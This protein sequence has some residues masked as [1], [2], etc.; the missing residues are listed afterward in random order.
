MAKFT[1]VRCGKQK[2]TAQ[3]C[4]LYAVYQVDYVTAPSICKRCCPTCCRKLPAAPEKKYKAVK[5]L[6]PRNPPT[7]V[8]A[9]TD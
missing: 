3:M 8:P 4:D 2:Q 7:Y 6:M 5:I 9:H 1:C